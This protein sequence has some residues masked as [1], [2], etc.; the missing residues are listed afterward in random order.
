LLASLAPVRK[1]PLTRD[2][3]RSQT[4]KSDLGK[5]RKIVQEVMNRGGADEAAGIAA[6][7]AHRMALKP[8][9]LAKLYDTLSKRDGKKRKAGA[10]A[11]DEDEDADPPT[12]ATTAGAPSAAAVPPTAGGGGATS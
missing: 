9:T 3:T 4:L 8:P 2:H 10:A 5:R 1:P 11:A 7:E 6:V 12:G